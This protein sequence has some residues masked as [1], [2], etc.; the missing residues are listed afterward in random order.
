MAHD[1]TKREILCPQQPSEQISGYLALLG[2][3]VH[4]G[5]Y[6]GQWM[7]QMKGLKREEE[8]SQSVSPQP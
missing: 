2:S 6:G 1:L 5:R 4:Q 3:R 8:R 7:P